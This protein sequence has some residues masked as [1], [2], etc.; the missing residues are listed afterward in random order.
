MV[1]VMQAVTRLAGPTTSRRLAPTYW[2]LS[3]DWAAMAMRIACAAKK[4]GKK[5][6]IAF[7]A[8][9]V[10]CLAEL[11]K[12]KQ[13]L[14]SISVN[15]ETSLCLSHPAGSMAYQDSYIS[16]LLIC[17]LVHLTMHPGRPGNIDTSFSSSLETWLSMVLMSNSCL[18]ML[19]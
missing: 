15:G 1:M 19:C 8:S 2:N 17:T 12:Q 18:L 14:R 3:T 16:V 11:L 4:E 9:E 5:L 6:T 7:E 10:M 13:N